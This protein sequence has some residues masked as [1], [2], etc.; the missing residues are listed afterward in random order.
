[1]WGMWAV[2]V[3]GEGA[4]FLCGLEETDAALRFPGIAFD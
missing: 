4:A 3:V 2:G 1:M